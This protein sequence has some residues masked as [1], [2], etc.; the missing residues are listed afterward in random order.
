M[1]R[2]GDSS[3]EL[4]VQCHVLR[5]EWATQIPSMSHHFV[6]EKEDLS[7]WFVST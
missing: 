1:V 2:E 6:V 3:Q 4:G 7:Q 5:P